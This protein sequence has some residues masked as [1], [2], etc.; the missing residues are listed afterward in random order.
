MHIFITCMLDAIY[1]INYRV[2]TI[3]LQILKKKKYQMKFFKLI[4]YLF[5]RTKNKIYAFAFVP[6][7]ILLYY[8]MIV[9]FCSGHLNT[10]TVVPQE[11]PHKGYYSA[12]HI[13]FVHASKRN[14]N[15]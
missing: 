9:L 4:S 1:F 6:F 14:D 11:V 2:V 5:N 10:F 15:E 3:L 12:T 7:L 13:M 8:P